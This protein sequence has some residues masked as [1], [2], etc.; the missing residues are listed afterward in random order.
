MLRV[1]RY[2]IL[3]IWIIS[4]SIVLTVSIL[5]IDNYGEQLILLL[6]ESLALGALFFA[7]VGW[8]LALDTQQELK[9]YVLLRSFGVIQ[10]VSALEIALYSKYWL[11][12][13]LWYTW[14]VFGLGLL[15]MLISLILQKNNI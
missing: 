4:F 9:W 14:L 13:Q 2:V 8:K 5:C 7:A 10:L 3:V 15:F 12:T 6:P 1:I 11:S